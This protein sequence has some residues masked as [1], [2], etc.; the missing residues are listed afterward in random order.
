M[1]VALFLSDYKQNLTIVHTNAVLFLLQH[2]QRLAQHG[3]DRPGWKWCH[4][5]TSFTHS[6]LGNL[7]LLVGGYGSEGGWIFYGR[8]S[9]WKRVSVANNWT[10][11]HALIHNTH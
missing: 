3:P 5:A 9:V 4:A 10:M 6:W 8:T 7:L 1:G 2:W 11:T